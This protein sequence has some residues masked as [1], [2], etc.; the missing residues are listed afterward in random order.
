MGGG[1]RTQ[2]RKMIEKK[3]VVEKREIFDG[4]QRG[5]K[6]VVISGEF[7]YR[8]KGEVLM[9]RQRLGKLN[10]FRGSE[11]AEPGTKPGERDTPTT[12]W[13]KKKPGFEQTSGRK[14]NQG[15][16]EGAPRVKG[17]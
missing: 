13:G 5:H 1:K 15:E 6:L 2:W 7:L 4:A 16:G 14:I 11:T 9:T 10:R 17:I 3:R 8:E 12:N